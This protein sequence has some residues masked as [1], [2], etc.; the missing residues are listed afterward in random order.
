M[1]IVGFNTTTTHEHHKNHEQH[2]SEVNT[3]EA[4]ARG[5][6]GRSEHEGSPRGTQK[7]IGWKQGRGTQ[8]LIGWRAV[9]HRN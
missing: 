4:R 8:K 6:Q 3:R 2:K 9:E 7:L 5:T 1:L